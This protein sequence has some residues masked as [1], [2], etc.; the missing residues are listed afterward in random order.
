[1]VK[2]EGVGHFLAH[3]VFTLVGVVVG[4]RIEIGAVHLG[5]ALGDMVA[6][7][8]DRR[9]PQPTIIAI[10]AVADLGGSEHHRAALAGGAA[11]DGRQH[12]AIAL[13]PVAR[14]LRQVRAPSPFKVEGA[15]IN[16]SCEQSLFT[17]VEFV[18]PE[19]S[20]LEGGRLLLGKTCIT[21]RQ[22]NR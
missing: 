11:D 3:D 18:L 2:A 9:Q 5:R 20:V 22:R 6:R 4:G 15:S 1:M 8:V 10:G 21:L 12:R 14:R 17:T 19:H 13:I 16:V 7:D